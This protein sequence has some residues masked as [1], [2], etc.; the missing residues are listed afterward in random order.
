MKIKTLVEKN[1]ILRFEMAQ[2]GMP[3]ISNPSEPSIPIKVVS[4]EWLILPF[5]VSIMT[6]SKVASLEEDA[7][8][9][10]DLLLLPFSVF[11]SIVRA[12]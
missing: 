5:R 2:L 10:R 3:Q 8:F 11:R 12:R 1:E 9:P 4:V 7:N 6:S